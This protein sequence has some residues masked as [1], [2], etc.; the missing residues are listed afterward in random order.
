MGPY[1][2]YQRPF[3]VLYNR[4]DIMANGD[5]PFAFKCMAEDDDHAREQCLNAEP[6]AD[7]LIVYAPRVRGAVE[8]NNDVEDAYY[9]YYY[10]QEEN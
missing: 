3:I 9:A 8:Q 10:Q 7:I 2:N 4:H 6:D 5:P 1:M